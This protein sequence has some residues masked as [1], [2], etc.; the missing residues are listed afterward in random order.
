MKNKVKFYLDPI[1]PYVFLAWHAFKKITEENQLEVEY[2]PIFLA[3]LLNHHGQKGPA[4]ITDKRRYTFIDVY[5]LATK[6]GL[7]IVGPPTHPF[8]PLPP[9]RMATSIDDNGQRKVFIE[10]MLNACWSEGKDISDYRVLITVANQ[11]GFDGAQLRKKS[12]LKTTKE[13]LIQN[14][15]AAIDIGIFGVPTFE[16]DG[17]IYWGSDRLDFVVDA[18]LGNPIKL[19]QAVLEKILARP[20]SAGRK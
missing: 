8:N 15:Q 7:D 3:A 11:V 20:S 17:E 9:L 1:S 13:R 14:T 10:A 16:V 2:V 5:R 4:E 6:A 19:D 18:S 12:S